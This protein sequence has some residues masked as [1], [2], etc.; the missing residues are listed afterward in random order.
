MRGRKPKPAALKLV[1]GNPGKRKILPEPEPTKGVPPPP[2]WI[3][4]IALEE[5]NRIADELNAIGLLARVD[6]A[7]LVLY[8]QLWQEYVTLQQHT[9]FRPVIEEPARGD[10]KRPRTSRNWAMT[11]LKNTRNQLL[12]VAAEFG[13]TPAAR[14]RLA[15]QAANSDDEFEN[16]RIAR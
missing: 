9:L 12:K 11:E 4:S 2:D 8:A 5:Y 3:G 16:F 1:D 7:A 14:A 10:E 15:G 6:Q 13:L